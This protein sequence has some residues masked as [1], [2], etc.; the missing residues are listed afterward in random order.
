VFLWKPDKD[1]RAACE[2]ACALARARDHAKRVSDDAGERIE[3]K[4]V[5]SNAI[6]F[7]R[8]PTA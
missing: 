4:I 7:S 2:G 1:E 8:V 3:Q 6:T 5:Y